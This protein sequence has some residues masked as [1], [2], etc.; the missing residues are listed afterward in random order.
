MSEG[1]K[2]RGRPP[3][4]ESKSQQR[5]LAAMA[6]DESWPAQVWP[7]EAFI[8]EEMEARGWE[9]FLLVKLMLRPVETYHLADMEKPLTEGCAVRLE[10]AFEISADTFLNIDKQ[11]WRCQRS[12]F[13]EEQADGSLLKK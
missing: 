9:E 12:G 5:R 10:R 4:P 1:S 3:T 6:D 7:V 13:Y 2:R 8:R 11:Y